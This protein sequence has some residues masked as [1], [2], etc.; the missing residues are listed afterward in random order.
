[1]IVTY[2]DKFYLQ[3]FGIYEG[4]SSQTGTFEFIK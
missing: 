2:V 1:M 4:R 3:W